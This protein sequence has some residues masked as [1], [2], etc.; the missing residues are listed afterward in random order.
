MGL[1]YCED[2]DV[3]R[4]IDD[5]VC[6]HYVGGSP[7]DN[8]LLCISCNSYIHESEAPLHSGHNTYRKFFMDP[9]THEET[10]P[11]D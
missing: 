1:G 2:L 11:A 9:L 10:Y 4:F 6:E 7:K 3:F 5:G 8:F